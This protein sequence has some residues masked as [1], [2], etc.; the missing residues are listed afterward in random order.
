MS[1]IDWLFMIIR[2]KIDKIP[3]R[4]TDSSKNVDEESFSPERNDNI[5]VNPIKIDVCEDLHQSQSL[6]SID[7]NFVPETQVLNEDKT[8]DV[9]TIH[10]FK[11]QVLD[12]GRTLL[13]GTAEDDVI[14]QNSLKSQQKVIPSTDIST[15]AMTKPV[16]QRKLSIDEISALLDAPIEEEKDAAIVYKLKCSKCE[17]NGKIDSFT[18]TFA[19]PLCGGTMYLIEVYANHSQHSP[20]E[21]KQQLC[22]LYSMSRRGDLHAQRTWRLLTS[23]SHSDR[24]LAEYMQQ[25]ITP[26]TTDKESG[27]P[28]QQQRIQISPFSKGGSHTQNTTNNNT[29]SSLW[30]NV[31]GSSSSV[32]ITNSSGSIIRPFVQ[33]T[34]SFTN[35]SRPTPSSVVKPRISIP[36]LERIY[37]IVNESYG[38][39]KFNPTKNSGLLYLFG[40]S[41]GKSSHLSSWSRRMI[42]VKAFVADT[43]KIN[44]KWRSPMTQERVN[45]L[46]GILRDLNWADQCKFNDFSVAINHRKED[47]SWL[48]NYNAFLKDAINISKNM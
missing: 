35:T 39:K 4:A 44:A 8:P 47:I 1:A 36:E 26:H 43:P 16:Q 27:S 24:V 45:T 34:T 2:S 46:I 41:V 9:N 40:Y 33:K 15:L 32:P 7:E 5:V 21:I 29:G 20:E 3:P 30:S 38:V 22:V 10:T 17:V 48:S 19:C 13:L 6:S 42:I 12:N 37:G 18:E 25:Y 14:S 31:Q 23:Q 11:P 28:P